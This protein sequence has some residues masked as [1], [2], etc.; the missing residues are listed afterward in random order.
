MRVR[1]TAAGLYAYPDL[2]IACA[3]LQF[4]DDTFDTLLNPTVIVEVVSESTEA[5]D[6]GEKFR[7]YRS[8]ESLTEY[9]L[10]SCQR[11]NVEL[12][13]RQPDG[14][15]N[16]TAKAGLKDSIDLKAV[17]CHL[18]LA[19]VYERVEFSTSLPFSREML[20]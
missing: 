1:V 9:L 13:V 20:R 8:L 17:D 5:Y 2:V 4:A 7:H 11:I 3:K 15:W 12:Y 19:D 16:F 10:I 14:T 6:R 18:L